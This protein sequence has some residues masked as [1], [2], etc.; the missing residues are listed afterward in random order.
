M[1]KRLPTLH[2]F[3]G[4]DLAWSSRNPTGL[5]AL[6]W[7]GDT[8]T[9]IEPL[10]E[11][12]AYSDEEIAAYINSAVSQEGVVIAIDAPLTVPNERG[13]RLGE[14]AL[15]AV[16]AR[17]HAG[18]HPANRTRLASYNGGRLRGE[19]LL[20]HLAA[21][22]VRHDPVL[23]PQLRTRQAFEAY[24]HPAMV[25]LFRLGGVLKYKAKPGIPH[26]QRLAAF[27]LYQQHLSRLR[28]SVPAL[29][30]PRSLLAKPHLLKKGKAL[31]AYE[32]Q[33]DAVFCAYLALYYWWWGAERCHIFGNAE[34][35]YMIAPVDERVFPRFRERLGH[36]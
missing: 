4:V 17:F 11:A 5:A 25:T 10:P 35:G 9:L 26:V 30:L 29:R 8:A 19:A 7:D 16:F 28:T 24:P 23:S 1:G 3:I 36:S 13:R 33:L 27:R 31:K 32:D 14:T 21:L 6:R 2:Y 34:Q 20:A 18:A 12:V 22:G 15:N